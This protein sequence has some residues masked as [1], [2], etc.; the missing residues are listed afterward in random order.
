ML[1]GENASRAAHGNSIRENMIRKAFPVLGLAI[2]AS[3][4]GVG[5]VAPLLPLYAEKMGAS[6][7]KSR[8]KSRNKPAK[9]DSILKVAEKLFAKKGFHEATVAEIAKKAGVSEGTI[10]EYFSTKEALLFSIPGEKSG[11]FREANLAILK[12]VDSSIN[13]LKILVFRH[14]ELF[15]LNPD[16]ANVTVMILRN[17]RNFL[18]TDEY[19]VVRSSAQVTIDVLKEGIKKGEF[20]SD[21]DPYVVRSIIW[22]SI[23]D[24][25]KRKFL[26]NKRE[27]DLMKFADSLVDILFKGILAP[28]EPPRLKVVFQKSCKIR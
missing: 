16:Y 2:F 20:R 27:L 4:L 28:Q 1:L 11:K 6:G 13:K 25:V 15:N 12:Y 9:R 7:K 8:K 10:Y 22:G 5:I 24:A 14:L 18:N 3:M 21:L 23:D 17:N 26:Y 19:Q